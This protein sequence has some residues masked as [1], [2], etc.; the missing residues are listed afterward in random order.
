[1][2]TSQNL[3]QEKEKAQNENN[4][5]Y[6]NQNHIFSFFFPPLVGR[7]S[8][9]GGVVWEGILMFFG[10]LIRHLFFYL[11]DPLLMD[12]TLQTPADVVKGISL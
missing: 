10:D 9:A 11:I 7:G 6:K 8:G 1:M 12:E 5:Y 2:C 3:K 4:N